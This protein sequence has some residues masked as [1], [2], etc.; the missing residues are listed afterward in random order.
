MVLA[1]KELFI[2]IYPLKGRL[3]PADVDRRSS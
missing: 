2:Q 1:L 3:Q